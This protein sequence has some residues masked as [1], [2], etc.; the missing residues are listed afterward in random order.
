M[1]A[2][3]G[4]VVLIGVAVLCSSDRKAIRFRTVGGAFAIQVA[5]GGLVLFSEPG[6]I[7]LEFIATQVQ[8]VINSANAGIEFSSADWPKAARASDSCSRSA[9]SPS[10]SSSRRS[11]RSSTTSA[12]CRLW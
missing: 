7:S 1:I 9:S 6:R 8:Y 2:L 10:S 11:S 4:M 3:L 5:I 12:S